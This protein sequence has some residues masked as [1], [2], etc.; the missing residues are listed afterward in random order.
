MTSSIIEN[1]YNG[2]RWNMAVKVYPEAP[3]PTFTSGSNDEDY[4]VEFYAVNMVMDQIKEEVFVTSSFT[5]SEGKDATCMPKR[6]YAGANRVNFTGSVLHNTDVKVGSVRYWQTDIDHRAI[7]AHNIDVKNHGMYNFKNSRYFKSGSVDFPEYNPTHMLA[8]NWDFST[9]LTSDSNGEFEIY[10][11]SSGSA[12]IDDIQV[13]SIG[14][15]YGGTGYGFPSNI[16]VVE[17]VFLSN[18]RFTAPDNLDPRSL[19]AIVEQDD[20]IKTPNSRPIKYYISFE[21]S[22]YNA[23]NDEIMR[24]FGG[25]REFNNLIGS[26]KNRYL[27]DYRELKN[28]KEVFFDKVQNVPDLDRYLDLYKWI[29]TTVSDVLKQVTPASALVNTKMDVIESHILE[30]AKYGTKLPTTEYRYTDPT[31]IA[32]GIGEM[33]YGWRSGHPP[34]PS[35]QSRNCT[36]WKERWDKSGTVS[37]ALATRYIALHYAKQKFD[38]MNIDS[39]LEKMQED[40]VYIPKAYRNNAFTI[41]ISSIYSTKDCD[42]E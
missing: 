3:Y 22:M 17:K 6:I 42:D 37:E 13:L 41:P 12:Q 34:I 8:L 38:L 30:R 23:I 26:P 2:D 16:S 40:I 4:K 15:V 7:Q 19:V 9:N 27:F 24:W 10:D 33:S 1:I 14:K 25:L 39:N 5:N 18:G 35:I 29:D 11:Y 32:K 36:W 20:I 31:G 21:K 28:L